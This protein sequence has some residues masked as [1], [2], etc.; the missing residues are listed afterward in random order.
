MMTAKTRQ[1]LK[2]KILQDLRQLEKEIC[3][4]EELIRP[5]PPQ[6]ALGDLAR[7]ELMHDQVISEKTLKEAIIRKNRLDY[8]LSK[9]G[10]DDFGLCMECEEKIALERLF[11]LP[12]SK[13]CIA[14]ASNLSSNR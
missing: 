4:L 6:C 1:Q 10:N 14:C 5:I 3:E 9:I 2:E 11:I 8:A 7:F 13:H 12:E